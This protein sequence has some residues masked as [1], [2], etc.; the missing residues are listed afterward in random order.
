MKVRRL[1]AGLVAA[2]LLLGLLP[3]TVLAAGGGSFTDI[4]DPDV[5]EAAEILHLLGVVDGTGGSAFNPGGSL[6]RAEFCKLAVEIMDMG[7]QEPAQR[8]RTIFLDVGP[9]HWAR[10]YINLAS[11]IPLSGSGSGSGGDKDGGTTTGGDRLI[12]GVGNGRFEPDRA[13][14]YGEAVA[15]LVRILGYNNAD[16]ATGVHWYDGYLGVAQSNGLTEGLSLSGGSKITRG[17]SALLFKNMLFTKIKGGTGDDSIYLVSRLKG[18][19]KD[20]AIILSIDTPTGTSTTS[21]VSVA[22]DVSYKTDRTSFPSALTGVRG[23]LVLDKSDKL[24]TVLPEETDTIRRVSVLGTA[25]ANKVPISGGERLSVSLD[26]P[27]WKS[28]EKSSTTY[29]KVWTNL[30][31]GTP[32]VFCYGSDG[33]VAYI[34]M[35]SA[36]AA[37]DTV[38][39]ARTKPNGTVNPFTSLT[40]GDKGYQLYKNGVPATVA[41]IRQYDVATYDSGAKILY[42]SDLRLTGRY[43]NAYPNTTAPSRIRMLGVEFKVLPGAAGDLAA[44]KPG[45]SVTLLLTSRGEVAGAVATSVAKTTVVG[46][47]NKVEQSSAEVE[48]LTT[49]Y[50]AEGNK[51]VFKGDP[52]LSGDSAKKLE[53][54]LVTVSSYKTGQISLNRLTSNGANGSLDVGGRT[55]GGVKLAEN[56]AMFERVG[57]SVPGRITFSQ[58]TRGSVPSSK[59]LYAGKDSTGKISTIVFDDVTGDQYTYGFARYESG[60]SVIQDGEEIERG[61]DTVTVVNGGKDLGPLNTTENF[62]YNEPVGIAA[63]IEKGTNPENPKLAGSVRLTAVKGVDRAAF[64]MDAETV[65][66]ENQVFP[67]S[68]TVVSYNKTTATW[69]TAGVDGV[70]AARAYAATLTVYYDKAPENGGK[71]RMVVVE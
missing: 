39:V 42:V 49:F 23:Q 60:K 44:F 13:I 27:V 46:V 70:E 61:S 64:D 37:S 41:D 2:V 45:D 6:T 4:S 1:I 3:G 28:G 47:V 51:V 21:T 36:S 71:I 20:D 30:Y 10:G 68:D 65:T 57:N 7:D 9:A 25:E 35:A 38:M 67:I 8:N 48:P 16:V 17:Q 22:G 24:L 63:S 18:S 11:S 34:Y 33:K 15:M 14:T 59:I 43:E 58:L 52:G 62:R 66:V 12:M 26:T 19:L 50:D 5:A 53:G 40:G 32:L 55:L 31:T 56:V 29:E 54:Q 69:F